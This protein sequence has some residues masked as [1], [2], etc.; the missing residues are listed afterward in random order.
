EKCDDAT[1]LRRAYLDAI[2]LLPAEDELQGFLQDTSSDKREKLIDYL[3]NNRQP[4]AEHWMTFCNDLLRNDE[5]TN[6]DGL[7]QP[8]TSWLYVSLLPT[9]PY[10]Q[11][12]MD[13][14]KPDPD[15]PTGFLDGV[16]WRGR[17]NA[18]Q[19]PVI[20]AAQSIS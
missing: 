14:L 17:I 7:R 12:L 10:D 19:R 18:R 8:V 3:L 5:Q 16:Q 2:G 6:I 20:Q 13:I 9:K 15:G 4:Y 11:L 1:F